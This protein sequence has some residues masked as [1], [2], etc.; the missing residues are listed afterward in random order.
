MT[1]LRRLA[2]AIAVAAI[3]L[4]AAYRFGLRSRQLAWGAT[5]SE[6]GKPLP[7]DDLLPRADLSATRAITIAAPAS[8]VWPWI[9]QIGQGRGGFYTYD[10]LENLVGCDIRS[11]SR[12][13]PEWQHPEAGDPFRLHPDIALTVATVEPGRVLVAR[14][15][16]DTGGGPP[17]Y[18][19]TW[20][21]AVE[22]QPDGRT[23][24][25]VRERYLYVRPGAAALV[26]PVSIVSFL[27]TRKML[28]GIKIRAEE[29]ARGSTGAVL[30]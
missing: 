2:L 7:G 18:D 29:G 12:I 25:I 9:A 19:F 1:A 28:E 27:M 13:V 23:R 10:W 17:P 20:C 30:H 22:E 15:A 14:G 11:A 3:T 8:G 24:L 16:V 5:A 4:A 26:E 21:F 6:P